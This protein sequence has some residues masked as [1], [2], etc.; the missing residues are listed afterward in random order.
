MDKRFCINVHSKRKRLADSDGVSFKA[1]LDGITKAGVFTDD[2]AKY[3][4]K[5]SYT[6]E[7][8]EV[9]ETI[10]TISRRLHEP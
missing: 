8:S 4:K 2:S 5:V 3:I 6:Q 9:E 10:I 1:A 7:T